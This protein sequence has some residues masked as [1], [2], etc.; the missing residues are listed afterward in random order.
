MHGDGGGGGWK[1]RVP[2]FCWATHVDR[3]TEAEFKLRYRVG[4]Q[5]FYELLKTLRPELEVHPVMSSRTRAGTPGT[6]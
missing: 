6:L 3:L 1:K 2:E 4:S 5:A